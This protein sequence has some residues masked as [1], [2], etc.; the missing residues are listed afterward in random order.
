MKYGAGGEVAKPCDREFMKL[1]NLAREKR[2]F[3]ERKFPDKGSA[4]RVCRRLS[5]G[6]MNVTRDAS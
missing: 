4:A 2:R 6:Q 1:H 3:S 5:V